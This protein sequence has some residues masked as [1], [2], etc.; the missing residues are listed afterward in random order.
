METTLAS[1]LYYAREGYWHHIFDICEEELRRG[2]DPLLAFWRAFAVFKEGSTTEAIRGLET[3]LNRREVQFA[4]VVALIHYHKHCKLVDQEALMSLKMQL[5]S[6]LTNASDQALITASQF[7]LLINKPE[8]ARRFINDIL[9]RNENSLQALNVFGWIECSTNG[10]QSQ[11]LPV[12]Q[13]IEEKSGDQVY[14]K[15]L[16]SLM[17][18]AKVF[19]L[20]KSFKNILEILNDILVKNPRFL[21]AMIE[22]AKVMMM[23]GDW[24]E[25]VEMV[26]RILSVSPRNIEALRIWIFYLLS[27]EANHTMAC[28]KLQELSTALNQ[29]EPKNPD[30]YMNIIKPI[31]RICGRREN[32]LRATLNLAQQAR[33]VRPDD[34]FILTELGEQF[35][36]LGD[37]NAAVQAFSEA[38]QKDETNLAPLHKIAH[39]RILQGQLDDA[40]QQLEF[41]TEI[42]ESTGRTPEVSLLASMIAWRRDH[43]RKQALKILDEALTLHVQ[44]SKQLSPGYDFYTKLNPDFLLEMAKEYLQFVGLNPLPK[45]AKAPHYLIRGMKLLETLTKQIPGITEAQL[46][47]AKSKYIANDT[48]SAQKCISICLQMDPDCIDALILSALIYVSSGEYTAASNTLEQALARNFKIRENPMFML[49]KGKC[50]MKMEKYAEALKT[51][52]ATLG[53]PGV[54]I[55]NDK[56]AKSGFLALS[57]EDRAAVYTNLALAYAHNDKISEATRT[58]QEA[59]GEFHGTSSEVQISITNS[60]ISLK[61]GDIKQ[62]LKILDGIAPDNPHFKEAKIAQGEIYLMHMQNRRLFAKCYYDIVGQDDSV[63]NYLLLG[64]S[65]MRIQEPEEAIKVYEKALKHKP[66]DLFLTKEIGRA[67]VLTHD[68]SRAIRYYESAVRS[69]PRKSEL[70]TDLAKL[71]LKLKDYE[72]ASRV[73]DEAL[74]GQIVDVPSLR[75]AAENF[76]LQAKV[77]LASRHDEDPLNLQP[78]PEA[79]NAYLNARTLQKQLL[80]KSREMQPE[81]FIKEKLKCADIHFLL[82]DYYEQREKNF[83][84]AQAFY[85]ESLNYNEMS[86]K[87]IISLAKLNL[88]KGDSQQCMHYCSMMLRIDPANEEA[89]TM[90][91]EL[92]LQNNQVDQAIACYQQLL[93]NKPDNYGILAKLIHL[94]YRAG[95]LS[96]TDKFLKSAEKHVGRHADAGLAFCKGL[97]LKL[98]GKMMEAQEEFNKARNDSEYGELASEIMID[99]YLNPD[100]EPFWTD[101]RNIGR[102]VTYAE[103]LLDE[104]KSKNYSIKAAVLECM[105]I[106]AKG[107]ANGINLA[108]EK[109]NMITNNNKNYVPAIVASAIGKLVLQKQQEAKNI[110]KNLSFIPYQAEFAEEFERGWLILADIYIEN[111]SNDLAKEMLTLCLK[112]NKSCSKAVEL[113][114]LLKEKEADFKGA[115]EYYENAWKLSKSA[116]IGFRLAFNY[117]KSKLNVRAIDVCKE[118]LELYPEYPRIREEILDRAREGIRP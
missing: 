78:L 88:K 75:Q 45:T 109:L 110:L 19:E 42:E 40:S 33:R 53:L 29:K 32:V 101:S 51:F 87:S 107:Q 62:A 73:I 84:Q 61:K 98:S 23:I 4:C 117:L 63:E 102:N 57:E 115:S 14:T 67:L 3:N 86:A 30:L 99:I 44:I 36:L 49:V 104:L 83:D 94:L 112:F 103:T 31:A 91:S 90:M 9:N 95:K 71:Y 7:L 92:L 81:Q 60:E 111:A 69:D 1:V 59:I 100:H 96:D 24:D 38:T 48:S 10:G 116:S 50:E 113:L 11:A 12:F 72:A 89:S 70:L 80:T 21:P 105:V 65:L 82:G 18:L 76:M 6:L 15:H 106:L 34:S 68:Y 79:M 54:R 20:T 17:G 46:L 56:A 58:M 74:K 16:D 85:I 114:G 25:I 13:K 55:P 35:R 41:L 43:D 5:K 118:V 93:E 97:F 77:M 108:L 27:R 22:K 26:H 66:D 47:L 39:C 28:Q 8:K 37:L 2:P 52:E 64:E